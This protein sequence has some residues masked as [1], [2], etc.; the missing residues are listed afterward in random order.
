MNG[1]ESCW[2][3]VDCSVRRGAC[4]QPWRRDHGQLRAS[5]ASGGSSVLGCSHPCLP[6]LPARHTHV[7]TPRLQPASAAP[8]R[9][10][11]PGVVLLTPCT[12]QLLKQESGVWVL[13]EGGE[14][15]LALH[16]LPQLL[17]LRHG[18]HEGPECWRPPWG[19]SRWDCVGERLFFG[20][21]VISMLLVLLVLRKR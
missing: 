6:V 19:K 16:G 1:A 7:H 13:Q 14:N 11:P 10:A 4:T 2:S 20:S 18:F 9:H 8:S 17:L 5:T 3:P 21:L 15:P 12:Q